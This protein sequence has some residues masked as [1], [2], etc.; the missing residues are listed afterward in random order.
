MSVPPRIDYDRVARHYDSHRGWEAEIP[1]R[2]LEC[3]S[4]RPVRGLTPAGPV[5]EL[6]CGTGNMTRWLLESWPGPVVALDLSRGMLGRAREKLGDARLLRASVERLPFQSGQFEAAL[7]AFFLHHV[8]APARVRLFT[9]L[10]RVL[11][12]SLLKRGRRK[13]KGVAFLTASHEQI[14]KSYMTRW[15][16][17][18]A[19][20]DCARFPDLDLL[21]EELLAAGFSDAAHDEVSRPVPKGGAEMLEKVRARFVSSLELLPPGEFEAG[22]AQMER[23]LATDGH[24]G[25]V[26][27]YATI[28]HARC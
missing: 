19:A 17:T 28:V 18:F 11:G 3:A 6:G 24:L 16:P 23:Q 27:W 21:R 22:V 1:L 14:R 20:V 7:G 5:L 13:P 9:E 12:A 4:G 2:V 8:E 26:S 25:D 15:F 10:R